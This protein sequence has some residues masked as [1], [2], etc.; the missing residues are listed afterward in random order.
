MNS[1]QNSDAA[2]AVMRVARGLLCIFWGI[3]VSLMLFS[4]ALSIQ[5]TFVLPAHLPG[6]MIIAIGVIWLWSAG[7]MS[8]AWR[9]LVKQ[10]IMALCL[11]IYFAPFLS[12]WEILPGTAYL[13]TNVWLF[14][15]TVAWLL[16]LLNRIAGDVA[17][18]TG[19]RSL[20]LETRFCQ[21]AVV[22][23]MALPLLIIYLQAALGA[24]IHGGSLFSEITQILIA[25]PAW[26]TLIFLFP[27]PMTMANLWR[28]R[29]Q[30]LGR[31]NI[32]HKP[33]EA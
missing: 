32:C 23:M 7:R 8:P 25:L 26:S 19:C 31:L 14:L 18:Q 15:L 24:M 33:V 16:H 27:F 3:P 30:C 2:F 20:A 9:P 12:W 6:V 10:A 21:W 5:T 28:A 17:E 11:A 13:L 22:L 4:Q 29:N 1:E